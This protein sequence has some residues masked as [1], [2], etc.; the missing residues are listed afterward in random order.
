M[1]RILV[2][3]G[4][5]GKEGI[6]N[7]VLTYLE[8]IDKEGITLHLGIAGNA[9]PDGLKRANAIGIPI[10]MLPGRNTDPVKYYLALKK[11][12]KRE[13]FDIVHVHGNS[14]TL[15]IDMAAARAGGCPV[16]IAHS[17]NTSCTHPVMDKLMRPVFYANYTDGFA[18][19][20]E[21]GRWLF[22]QR[23]FTVIPNG[24]DINRFLFREKDR[25][26]IRRQ[27]GIEDKIIIGHAGVMNAQKNHTFL[28]DIFNEICT[29]SDRYVLWLLGEDGG[30][31]A[32]LEEKIRR[33]NLQEKI[34]FLGFRPDVER[35][36]CA[37]DIMVFPSLYEG[38]PNAVIE[39]QISGLPCILSDT[40]TRECK[41]MDNITFL[42]LGAEAKAWADKITSTAIAERSEGQDMIRSKMMEAGFDIAQNVVRLK[43]LYQHLA[44]AKGS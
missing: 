43:S 24:K 8:K 10:H 18:C 1:V 14:A 5:L 32:L 12:V 27:Y 16:R 34:M 2:I 23:P 15:G 40:I 41:I 26:A 44:L 29:G 28:L 31:K 21:A 37:M 19:G 22:R 39:W 38:L 30:T 13:H 3:L 4:G 7:S 33:C 42:P 36:L 20:E 11:L 17:R 9:E 6:T 35:Y 25:V